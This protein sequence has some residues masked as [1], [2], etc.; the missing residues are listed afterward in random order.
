MFF[1]YNILHNI[2]FQRF[3]KVLRNEL[4]IFNCKQDKDNFRLFITFLFFRITLK[5][6]NYYFR[7]W[8]WRLLRLFEDRQYSGKI[9]T[10]NKNYKIMSLGTYC[11]P[12][13]I[14]TFCGLKPC[15]QDGEKSCPFDLAFFTNIDKIAE[16]IENKFICLYD[17]LEYELPE[18]FKYKCW[19]NKKLN[20]IFNHE[21]TFSK[22]ELI[23]RYNSRIK[24][25]YDYFANKNFHKFCIIATNTEVSESQIK[26][27]KS[28]LLK[29]MDIEEFDIILINQSPSFI[30][31]KLNNVY[32][33]N[34][35]KNCRNFSSINKKG[36]WVGELRRRKMPE[37]QKIYNEITSELIDI[38][39]NRMSR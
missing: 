19:A 5:T 20:A 12:R 3:F 15:K 17:G 28:V 27:L 26:N 37:A 23:D 10:I 24:N 8:F 21:Y 9:A 22:N 32:V 7:Y 33:I 1:V 39:G 35:N 13:V 29:F 14:T 36:D 6:P 25:L 38:I 4:M 16:L 34:Q 2:N 31:L 30:D 11:L 18:G